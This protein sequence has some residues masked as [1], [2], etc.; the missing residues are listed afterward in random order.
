[1]ASGSFPEPLIKAIAQEYKLDSTPDIGGTLADVLVDSAWVAGLEK[2]RE[3][4]AVSFAQR[5]MP[6]AIPF[7]PKRM[8]LRSIR[9]MAEAT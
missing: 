2:C 1:V 3:A 5:L 7:I 8:L 6:A 9:K 4:L